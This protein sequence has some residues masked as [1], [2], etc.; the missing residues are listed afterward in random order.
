MNAFAGDLA[1]HQPNCVLTADPLYILPRKVVVSSLNESGYTGVNQERN[2][3]SDSPLTVGIIGTGVGLRTHF[4]G[5]TSVPGVEV[6]GVVGSSLQRSEELL[7]KAGFPSQLACTIEKL[8]SAD[9]DL[10][11]ITTPPAAREFYLSWLSGSSSALL[12]EKPVA[13]NS[14]E[15]ASLYRQ[16]IGSDRLM[17]HN[18]QLRGL[19]AFQYVRKLVSDGKIGRVYS[20]RLR[21]RTSG[22]RTTRL[23]DWQASRSKG[24]G[25]RLA[26][27]PHLLD[28][29]VFVTGHEF[30]DVPRPF[31]SGQHF[32]TAATPRGTWTTMLQDQDDAADEVF[33]AGLF[34]GD[35]W[36]DLT[37]TCIGVGPRLL[38]FDLEGTEGLIHFSF[39]DGR[40]ELD[41][42]TDSEQLHYSLSDNGGLVP[43]GITDPPALNPSLFRV[44]FPSYAREIVAT[45]RGTSTGPN[46]ASLLDGIDT[47]AILDALGE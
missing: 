2:I 30:E 47:L 5:F 10:V 15:A 37:C 14:I 28:L 6:V 13:R 11:C 29:G 23:P 41:V 20:A 8:V 33:S 38:E 19:A 18:V 25:E 26:M 21:E 35:C 36:T 24:G 22:F 40:G 43:A 45:L 34:I 46:L 31:G 7:A 27:G 39:V 3:M 16:F 17:F 4:P 9:P 42:F 44:A 1:R 12:V 32:G